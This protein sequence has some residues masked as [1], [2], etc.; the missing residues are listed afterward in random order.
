MVEVPA[1]ATV[2]WGEADVPLGVNLYAKGIDEVEALAR[3]FTDELKSEKA[4]YHNDIPLLVSVDNVSQPPGQIIT[5]YEGFEAI[6]EFKINGYFRLNNDGLVIDSRPL[7]AHKDE[8]IA[9]IKSIALRLRQRDEQEVPA[10][11][12]NC[13]EHAFL[14]DKQN[15]T[16]DDLLEHIRVGFRL[17]E[18]PDAHFSIYVAP[19]NPYNPEGDSLETKT[20]RFFE[21]PATPEEKKMLAAIK[22]LRRRARQIYDWHTGFEAL[23]RMP[24]EEGSHAHHE[25]QMKFTGVPR[26]VLRPYADIQFQTGVANDAAG[27]TQPSLKDEEAIAIWD[28][29]TS[30]IRVR[31]T[32]AAALKGS[33]A[34]S[35]ARRPLGELAATGRVCPQTGWW[36][37]S[38][39]ADIQGGRRQH[40]TAGE[41]MPRVV[42]PVEPSLWQKLKGQRAVTTRATVWKLVDYADKPAAPT[43]AQASTTGGSGGAGGPQ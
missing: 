29:I 36:E 30:T 9:L 35:S 39:S 16:E 38:E 4:I 15:P 26:D 25:F 33:G 43:V 20:K 21:D 13:I 34:D 42:F 10:E 11:P 23:M 37:A 41:R 31:P 5:G 3:K 28:K 8:T 40:F 1:S 12:G 7:R 14:S 19:A 2:V 32:G 27:A 18:F 24:D 22:V 17:K 6:D